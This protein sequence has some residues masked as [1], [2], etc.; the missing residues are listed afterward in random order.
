MPAVVTCSTTSPSMT[1]SKA[2]RRTAG[3]D[4]GLHGFEPAR[5]KDVDG[6]RRGVR[7]RDGEAVISEQPR[8]AAAACARVEHTPPGPSHQGLAEEQPLP[9]RV[10]RADERGRGAPLV[11]RTVGRA[12]RRQGDHDNRRPMR[13]TSGGRRAWREE[14]ESERRFVGWVRWVVRAQGVGKSQEQRSWGFPRTRRSC[15]PGRPTAQGFIVIRVLSP[16]GCQEVLDV[17]PVPAPNRRAYARRVSPLLYLDPGPEACCSRRSPAAS[18]ESSSRASCTGLGCCASCA[19]AAT[20]PTAPRPRPRSA[21]SW[22]PSS[23]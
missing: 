13:R 4:V 18:P 12:A 22:A 17:W 11:H 5:A 16:P 14:L 10:P 20:S 21:V 3:P 8:E 19:C 6:A 7:H 9:E 1:R 23:T 2:R 15:R